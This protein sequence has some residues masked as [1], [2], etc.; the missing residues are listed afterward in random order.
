MEADAGDIVIDGGELKVAGTDK[1]L[2]WHEVCLAAYT[3]HNLPEGMEPGLKETSFY[4]P[5][6]FTFPA[7]AFI[8]EVEVDPAHRRHHHRR[9]SSRWTTSA[10]SSIR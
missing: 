9:T 6:N 5:A 3:A 8:C 1:K 7:G 4:D 10:P 2:A